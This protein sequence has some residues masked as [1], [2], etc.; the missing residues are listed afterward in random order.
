MLYNNGSSIIIRSIII[1]IV[2][3]EVSYALFC[4]FIFLQLSRFTMKRQYFLNVCVRNTYFSMQLTFQHS[5]F[6]IVLCQI[7]DIYVELNREMHFKRFLSKL[8][9]IDYR[10][11][12]TTTENS[13]NECMLIGFWLFFCVQ[14]KGFC[15]LPF[16]HN[17]FKQGFHLF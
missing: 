17:H 11:D 2:I 16:I 15:A 14:N 4:G 13:L 12:Q 6:M 5:I 9:R 8:I 3:V 1:H 10:V 7:V